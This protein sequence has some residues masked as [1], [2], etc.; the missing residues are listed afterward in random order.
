M[1]Q[2]QIKCVVL[3]EKFSVQSNMENMY[4]ITI[5]T[6]EITIRNYRVKWNV[7]DKNKMDFTKFKAFVFVCTVRHKTFH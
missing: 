1:H 3:T 7:S 4:H 2:S 6:L 5:I